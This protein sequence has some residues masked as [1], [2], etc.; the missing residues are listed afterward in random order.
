MSKPGAL[1]PRISPNRTLCALVIIFL[2]SWPFVCSSPS[3]ISGLVCDEPCAE[4]QTSD[5]DGLCHPATSQDGEGSFGS[6]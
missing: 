5:P 1:S 6:A 2:A 4:R 3:S